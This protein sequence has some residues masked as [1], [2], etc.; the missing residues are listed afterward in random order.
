MLTTN[1]MLSQLPSFIAEDP[2]VKELLT[3]KNREV[4]LIDEV[5]A[6]ILK[7]F[8]VDTATW[9]LRREWRS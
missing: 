1:N 2:Y 7:Q 4:N 8:N 5:Q 6:D 3:S 9:G